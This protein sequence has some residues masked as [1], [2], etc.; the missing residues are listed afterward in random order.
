MNEN[1]I[2]KEVVDAAFAIHSKLG[3]GLLESVYE[4]L[5]ADE[6]ISR[7]LSVKKQVPIDIKYNGKEF[8]EAFRADLI[9]NDK[10]IIELKSVEHLNP[11]IKNSC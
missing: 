3:P 5:L 11:F 7:G 4:V 6:L 9:V 1:K 2:A 10:I 8:L